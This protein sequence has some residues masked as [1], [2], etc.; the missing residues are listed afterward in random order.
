MKICKV[1]NCERK[2]RRNGYCNAHS[3]QFRLFG[4]THSISPII[5]SRN[6]NSGRHMA[7]GYV[8]LAKYN[9]FGDAGYIY[10]H[11]LIME[12]HLG[13]ELLPEEIVHHRNDIRDDNRLENFFLFEN[14][15][16]HLKWHWYIS[17][18]V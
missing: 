10:E 14:N 6:K 8:V 1:E 7:N 18:L 12:Q 15:V 13:R 5:R 11:R 3:E 2:H 17:R 16:Q 4:K 9:D